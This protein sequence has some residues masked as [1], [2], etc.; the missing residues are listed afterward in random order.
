[1]DL[2]KRHLFTSLKRLVDL[3]LIVA[4]SRKPRGTVEK[5]QYRNSLGEQLWGSLSAVSLWEG[6]KLQAFG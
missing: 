5:E 1:M 2:N 4:M 6:R 3:V